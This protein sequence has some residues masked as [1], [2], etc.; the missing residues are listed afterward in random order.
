MDRSNEPESFPSDHADAWSQ[1][2]LSIPQ[3]ARMLAVAERSIYG[4]L[5]SG[6]LT[7]VTI[8]GRLMVRADELA[9][10]RR[11]PSGRARTL[12]LCWRETPPGNAQILTITTVPVRTGQQHV[13]QQRLRKLRSSTHL[14]PGTIA[15]YIAQ[16]R[17]QP[18]IIHILLVWSEWA[19][20]SEEERQAALA[21]FRAELAD[22]LAW[23]AASSTEGV[24]LLHTSSGTRPRHARESPS[25]EKPARIRK[26]G[27][28]LP[29]FP[30]PDEPPDADAD[31]HPALHDDG[32]ADRDS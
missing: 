26:Q 23:E 28:P 11:I 30:A 7:R 4:Y 20:P 19:T 12:P 6:K 15:R 25:D 3:A 21:V 10:F 22:V 5:A 16:D 8:E 2:Y 17:N 27:H 13:F 24:G 32:E 31:V 29:D 9:A 18:E 14:L 1:I